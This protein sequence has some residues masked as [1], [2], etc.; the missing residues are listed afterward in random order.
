MDCVGS[1]SI[2]LSSRLWRQE[3]GDEAGGIGVRY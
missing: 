3:Y 2:A 1:D